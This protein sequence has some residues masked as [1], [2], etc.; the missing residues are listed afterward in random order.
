MNK[1]TIRDLTP[2]Q[3]AAA[4]PHFWATEPM[5]GRSICRAVRVKGA[6]GP[7]PYLAGEGKK[8]RVIATGD[9]GGEAGAACDAHN[10]AVLALVRS[11]VI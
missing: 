6:D 5:G 10:L 8:R 7:F 2:A 11:L 9:E 1:L 4:E 3:L